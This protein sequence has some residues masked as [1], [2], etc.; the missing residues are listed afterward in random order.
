MPCSDH[1]VILKATAQHGRRETA[2]LC[3]KI[4]GGA[5][6]PVA[7]KLC[8]IP[9]LTLSTSKPT[10]GRC[11]EAVPLK[12]HSYTLVPNIFP[13]ISVSP[14]CVVFIYFFPNKI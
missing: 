10:N 8:T 12:F 11:Y 9:V 6:L 1:A 13:F 5:A 3:F 7:A 2:V 4:D 14:D